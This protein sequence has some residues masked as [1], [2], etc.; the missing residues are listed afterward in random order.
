MMKFFSIRLLILTV[1]IGLLSR[2]TFANPI[3]F[4]TF[5]QPP[6]IYHQ[7]GQLNGI[8]VD[9]VKA[10]F[11]K[12]GKPVNFTTYPFSRALK[13]VQENK[14]D[15]IFA[16]VKN[17]SRAE[18]LIFSNQILLSQDAILLV[19]HDSDIHYNGKLASLSNFRFATLRS[20]T[21]G[22]QWQN[23]VAN[24][25]INQV[26][27]LTSFRQSLLMLEKNRVDIV[28]GSH[29]TLSQEIK[30][31]NHQHKYRVL[32]PP[33]ESVPTYI[34]FA[35]TEQNYKLSAQFDQAIEALKQNGQYQQIIQVHLESAS[36]N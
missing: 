7:D 35:K 18:D 31:L 13:M 11:K 22:K 32:P 9:I 24:K 16:I 25:V 20:A 17:K 26:V 28:I 34:A 14:A 30:N 27:E 10:V 12:I 2:F 1:T 21:Y 36:L 23:A 15:A 3:E 6:V 19:N 5:E 29:I 8:A 33:L 4:A